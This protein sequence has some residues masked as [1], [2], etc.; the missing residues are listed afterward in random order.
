MTP[1]VGGS[2]NIYREESLYNEKR[3]RHKDET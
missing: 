1:L 2:K 3:K